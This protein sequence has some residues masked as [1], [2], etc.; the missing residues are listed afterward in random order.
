MLRDQKRLWNWFHNLNVEH[1]AKTGK[2]IFYNEAASFLT[3]Q[4]QSGI[5]SDGSIVAQQQCL[6]SAAI[7]NWLLNELH[8]IAEGQKKP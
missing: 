7:Q 1:F 8:F 2:F 6:K 3:V 4:R 5:F